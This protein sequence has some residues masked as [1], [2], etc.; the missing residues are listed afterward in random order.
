MNNSLTL[1]SNSSG[2]FMMAIMFLAFLALAMNPELAL[3]SFSFKEKLCK[4]LNCFFGNDIVVFVATVAIIFLGIGAFFGKL[5]WGLVIVVVI[6]IVVVAGAGQIAV[7]VA[8][9]G[10]SCATMSGGNACS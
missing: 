6:G 1:N 7:I 3:A 4:V 8:G 2:K 9:G 5:N 10:T